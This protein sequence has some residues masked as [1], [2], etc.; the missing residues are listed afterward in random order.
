VAAGGEIELNLVRASV[1]TVRRSGPARIEITS[2][3]AK[4]VDVASFRV[5]QTGR[6]MRVIDIYPP[7]PSL[8]RGECEPPE[9]GRG[10]FLHSDIVLDA[11]LYLPPGIGVGGH[12]MS[13]REPPATQSLFGAPP[14]KKA[15]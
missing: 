14:G 5:E 7:H 13:Q 10:D 4:N 15:R 9:D 2:R 3:N 1:R 6:G 11:V 12:I 8:F